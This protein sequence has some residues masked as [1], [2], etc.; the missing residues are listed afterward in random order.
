M[1]STLALLLLILSFTII[2][3][4]NKPESKSLIKLSDDNFAEKT[5][6]GVVLVDFWATWCGPCRAQAPTI[7]ALADE[8]NG[9][10]KVGK[11]DV[12][13]C[14][15]TA[16]HYGIQSIPTMIIFVDG[17]EA[18]RFVGLQSKGSLESALEKYVTK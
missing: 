2:S 7:S 3:C 11:V 17:K 1:K 12:D 9:K 13:E 14:P 4:N 8:S 10:Y 15:S 18:E 5:A 6:G 16:A